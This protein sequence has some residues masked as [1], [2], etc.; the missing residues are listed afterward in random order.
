MTQDWWLNALWSVVPTLIIGALFGLI[1]YAALNADRK[2][3]EIRA[4]VER[5]YE[6]KTGKKVPPADGAPRA[7]APAAS[8]PEVADAGEFPAAHTSSLEMPKSDAP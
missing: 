6:A 1:L 4:E 3:R 7:T 5:E 8:E 2:V